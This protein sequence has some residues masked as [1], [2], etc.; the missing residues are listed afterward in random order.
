M[1]EGAPT[2]IQVADRFH[3]VS[4]LSDAVERSLWPFRSVLK[5]A[6]QRLPLAIAKTASTK[7][8]GNTAQAIADREIQAAALQNHQQ[9][10]QRQ[11]QVKALHAQ[12]LSYA[13]IAIRVSISRSTI[14][15]CIRNALLPPTPDHRSSFG[16]SILA[17]ISLSYLPYGTR[18]FIR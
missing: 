2:A 10:L 3:I 12:K 18:G 8:L 6:E 13:K 15:R 7:A 17:N 5:G 14:H 4:N 9:R 16:S 1:D 11:C